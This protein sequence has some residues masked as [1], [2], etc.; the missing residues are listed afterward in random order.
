MNTLIQAERGIAAAPQSQLETEQDTDRQA[1]AK[2]LGPGFRITPIGCRRYRCNR[3]DLPSS[4]Y[5][6]G[7]LAETLL[8]RVTGAS[9]ERLSDRESTSGRAR[10][11]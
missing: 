1:V 7:H 11:W 3:Y 10:P 5:P 4:L 9:I 8:L 2:H 6:T